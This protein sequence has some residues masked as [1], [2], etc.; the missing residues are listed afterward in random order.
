MDL[1]LV[2]NS[3][4]FVLTKEPTSS[5]RHKRQGIVDPVVGDPAVL[6]T[7]DVDRLEMDLAVSWSDARN[8]FRVK[9]AIRR[10]APNCTDWTISRD[11]PARFGSQN[12]AYAG[13]T[14]GVDICLAAS[15]GLKIE[16]RHDCPDD[17]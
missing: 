15:F 17:P 7:H 16:S 6:G 10:K 11:S 4:C 13:A 2:Q 3:R 1:Y 5:L 14:D 9:T 12:Q 8:A